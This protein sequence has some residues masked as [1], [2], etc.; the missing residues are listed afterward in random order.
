[1]GIKNPGLSGPGFHERT[2]MRFPSDQVHH[3][4]KNGDGTDERTHDGVEDLVIH[5]TH[6]K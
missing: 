4:S 5:I 3:N 2:I 6:S 1:M